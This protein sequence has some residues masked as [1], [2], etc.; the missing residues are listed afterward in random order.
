MLSVSGAVGGYE[1]ISAV[2][3]DFFAGEAGEAGPALDKSGTDTVPL[4]SFSVAFDW[5][6]ANQFRID[7]D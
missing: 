5:G 6:C 3:A 2:D 1:L 4:L 7:R